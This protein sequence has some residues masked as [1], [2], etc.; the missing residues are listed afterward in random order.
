[1]VLQ[2]QNIL[3]HELQASQMP[4]NKAW[5]LNPL[6]TPIPGSG[7]QGSIHWGLSGLF[8]WQ[9]F[10]DHLLYCSP[11]GFLIHS[12]AVSSPEQFETNQLF[13]VYLYYTVNWSL[14]HSTSSK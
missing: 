8:Y 4:E 10:T 14:I 9:T 11:E 6:R 1:M 13:C 2:P 5:V 3:E 7:N 12:F